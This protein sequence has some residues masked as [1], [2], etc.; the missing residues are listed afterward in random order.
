M[1]RRRMTLITTNQAATT[2]SGHRGGSWR[3]DGIVLDRGHRSMALSSS[4][5][6]QEVL[7]ARLVVGDQRT[8][9]DV[10]LDRLAAEPLLAADD[11]P[12]RRSVEAG[13]S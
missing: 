8:R 3:R 12:S 11:R 4:R 6:T 2:S 10:A 1:A 9:A 5:R 13:E 7:G